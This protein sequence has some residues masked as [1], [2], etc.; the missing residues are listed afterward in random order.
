MGGKDPEF[1]VTDEDA[2]MMML[3]S[4]FSKLHPQVVHVA[5]NEKI[6]Q[7]NWSS[8]SKERRVLGGS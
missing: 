5:H 6:T 8:S 3:S 4:L 1:I 2:S 7:E